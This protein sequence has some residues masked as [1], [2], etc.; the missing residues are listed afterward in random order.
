M[1]E[2]FGRVL[3]W[4]ASTDTKQATNAAL[5]SPV[6]YDGITYRTDSAAYRK[7]KFIN[8]FDDYFI[9]DSI[10]FYYLFTERHSMVDNR[11]KNT[12]WHTEDGLRWDLCFNYD[13][14]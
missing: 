1:K 11:A 9:S 3:P 14:D 7:A 12:F 4:V 10:M 2:S 8:E 13:N 5:S 6:A